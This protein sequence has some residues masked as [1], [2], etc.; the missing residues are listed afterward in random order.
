MAVP[1][2]PTDAAPAL[3]ADNTFRPMFVRVGLDRKYAKAR[4]YTSDGYVVY[5]TAQYC[6][7]VR[8][9][10]GRFVEQLSLAGAHVDIARLRERG[11]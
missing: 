5:K 10:E 6:Y 4:W 3:I 9:L 8:D 2:T 11:R 1:D 7:W